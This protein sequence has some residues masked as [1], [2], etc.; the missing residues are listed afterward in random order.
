MTAKRKRLEALEARARAWKVAHPPAFKGPVITP[1]EM[2]GKTADELADLYRQRG[3]K[4]APPGQMP[5]PGEM[6]HPDTM[7]AMTAPE[8]VRLYFQDNT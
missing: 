2:Q 7:N 3:G 4:F 5:R 8:L 1:E 6:I